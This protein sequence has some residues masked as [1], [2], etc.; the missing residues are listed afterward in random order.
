MSVLDRFIRRLMKKRKEENGQYPLITTSILWRFSF[1][2][3]GL[4]A[5]QGGVTSGAPFAFFTSCSRDDVIRNFYE[6]AIRRSGQFPMQQAYS[7]DSV[8]T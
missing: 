1:K 7:E 8:V 2:A 6:T 3:S 5:W 4:S